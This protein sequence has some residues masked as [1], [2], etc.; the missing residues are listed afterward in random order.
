MDLLLLLNYLVIT[1]II[2]GKIHLE[3][4][5]Q[6]EYLQWDIKLKSFSCY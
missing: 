5:S 1:E 4:T 2:Q 6:V 3:A